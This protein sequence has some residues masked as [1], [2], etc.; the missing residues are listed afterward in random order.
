[1]PNKAA[2][3]NP[4]LTAFMVFAFLSVST[5]ILIINLHS[6]KIMYFFIWYIVLVL[7][8]GLVQD[9]L[10]FCNKLHNKYKKSTMKFIVFCINCLI[11]TMKFALYIGIYQAL[12]FIL[13]NQYIAGYLVFL[14]LFTPPI[15]YN[16]QGSKMSVIYSVLFIWHFDISYIVSYVRVVVM[17]YAVISKAN[18]LLRLPSLEGYVYDAIL[19]SLAVEKLLQI[20]PQKSLEI[21][22]DGKKRNKD[23]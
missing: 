22:L 9:W 8:L 4:L 18:P 12:A 19:T 15:I 16:L 11:L 1:M 14:T 13:R 3:K 7:F 17:I 23:A 5:I 2:K 20:A 10:Y 6:F 21:V